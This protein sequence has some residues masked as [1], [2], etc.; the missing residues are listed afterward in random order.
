MSRAAPIAGAFALA[1]ALHLGAAFAL[2]ARL[3]GQGGADV[4]AG[5]P[6]LA[7]APPTLAA[8]VTD[9]QTAPEVMDRA[10]VPQPPPTGAHA[11][12]APQAQRHSPPAAAAPTAPIAADNADAAPRAAEPPRQAPPE[13]RLPAPAPL[14]APAAGAALLPPAP[15]IAA[16]AA[17][18][19]LTPPAPIA[20]DAKPQGAVPP[21]PAPHAP[22]SAP[23]E[24]APPE[25]LTTDAAPPDAPTA[26]TG[27]A[28]PDAPRPRPDSGTS[29]AGAAVAPAAKGAARAGAGAADAETAWGV[30]I[31]AGLAAQRPRFARAIGAAF[32]TVELRLEIA[33]DGRLLA[34]SVARSSGSPALDALGLAIARAAAPFAPAPDGI[35][36]SAVFT[37]PLSFTP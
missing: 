6:A 12:G 19:R 35:A 10:P 28:P 8:L 20:A 37:V 5:A 32:G 30:A 7:A 33:R 18:Q 15:E 14:R 29:S 9:W 17:P 31:R 4:A 16:P 24:S 21:T 1:L 22:V 13:A 3:G 25:P 27:A 34:V 11:A 2:L 23:P 36:A 26:A